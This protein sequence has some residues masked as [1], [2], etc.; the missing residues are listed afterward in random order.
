MLSALRMPLDEGGLSGE[1]ILCPIYCS[2]AFKDEF[3]PM[4]S[5]IYGYAAITTENRLAFASFNALGQ[6]HKYGAYR[7]EKLTKLKISKCFSVRTFKMTFDDNGKRRRMQI[8]ANKRVFGSDLAEQETNLAE[9]AG[10][11]SELQ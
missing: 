2:F 11:M 9:F 6:V 4:T 7:L 5:V 10:R 3:L 8:N 1:T